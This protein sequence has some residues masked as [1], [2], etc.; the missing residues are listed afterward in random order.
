MNDWKNKIFDDAWK[1]LVGLAGGSSVTGF[2]IDKLQ[3]VPLE[4]WLVVLILCLLFILLGLYWN[5]P[6][7]ISTYRKR[8]ILRYWDDFKEVVSE[9]PSSQD[10]KRKK[11]LNKKYICLKRK[12]KSVL[13]A[14]RPNIISYLEDKYKNR[15]AKAPD[16]VLGNFHGFFQA[17]SLETWQKE[18]RWKPDELHGFDDLV[19]EIL[20]LKV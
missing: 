9:Y 19:Q 5:F 2:L 11:K 15:G 4:A 8:R 17:V 1:Y 20:H 7:L 16:L 3:F 12:I 14:Y 18:A 6:K 10:E 13:V